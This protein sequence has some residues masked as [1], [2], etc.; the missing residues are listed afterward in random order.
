M[1]TLPNFPKLALQSCSNISVSFLVAFGRFEKPLE[2]VLVLASPSSFQSV[3]LL[4]F[5]FLIEPSGFYCDS[6]FITMFSK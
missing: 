2:T 3:P 6:K 1:Q 5:I 4:F